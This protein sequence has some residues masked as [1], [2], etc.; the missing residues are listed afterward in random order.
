MNRKLWGLLWLAGFIWFY[1][2]TNKEQYNVKVLLTNDIINPNYIGNG[3]QWDAYPE[4]TLWG[5]AISDEDWSKLF[6]RLDFMKPNYVRCLINSP[7]RYYDSKTGK[8]DK[9]RNVESLAKLLG[10]CQK[11]NI[12]VLF[13]EFNPPTWEMKD[14][15]EWIA[16]AADYLNYLVN[17]LGFSCIKYYNLFN[18]PD[19]DWASTNGDYELWKRMVLMFHEKMKDYPGLSQKVQIAGPD[20]VMGY[21]NPSSP[22]KSYEWVEQTAQDLDDVIGIYDIHAYPGQHQVRSGAFASELKK[23]KAHVPEAKQI[24]VGEAGYKYWR[25]EDSL[26]MAEYNR[27][28]EANPFTLGSDCNMLVY[29]FFYGLDMPLLAM[30][31]MNGGYSGIAAWM[32]DDA[33]HSNGDAGNIHDIKLWGMWNIL[34]EEVFGLPDEENIRPWFYSW[35]LMCRYFPSGSHIVNVNYPDIPGIRMTGGIKDGKQT[36]AM[37]NFSDVDFQIEIILSQPFQNAKMYIYKEENRLEDN[38]GFP[39]PVETG[40]QSKRKFQT[41]LKNQSFV[42]ITDLS[43]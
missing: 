33:M 8:Y 19:G 37:V 14:D 38:D 5:S 30:E 35:S 20:I 2:C 1:G 32:L 23:Y 12:T 18:E 28:A 17:E 36:I 11:N 22:F 10:Y 15:P 21:N 26:L 40:I 42:L 27:R 24:I 3:V 6:K 16:M 13:G 4:A 31:V 9:T 25:Q 29:D 34:G 39:V 41:L 7:F 43:Y